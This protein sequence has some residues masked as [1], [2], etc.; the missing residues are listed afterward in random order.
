METVLNIFLQLGVDSSVFYQFAVVAVIF[1]LAKVLFL[2]KLQN[3][4]ETREEKTTGLEAE[5]N[6]NFE[7][8]EKM[9]EEYKSAITDA[10][11]K[12]KN[13]MMSEKS[14]F[15]KENEKAYKAKEAEM[16]TYTENMKKEILA[17]V[18][19]TEEKISSEVDGLSDMLIS[20]FSGK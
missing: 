19:A 18:G 6:S 3:V 9:G 11:M 13:E 1:V 4:I 10:Q 20:R 7:K 14:T 16:E 8:I 2:D 15:T 17:E 5:A 12:L